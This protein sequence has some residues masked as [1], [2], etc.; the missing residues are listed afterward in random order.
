MA[1]M[2]DMLNDSDVEGIAAFYARQKARSVVYVM[3]PGK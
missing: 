1:A 3:V 2:S